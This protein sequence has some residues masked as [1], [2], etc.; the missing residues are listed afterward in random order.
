MERT[1]SGIFRAMRR[2]RWALSLAFGYALLLNALLAG[3]LDTQAVAAAL[4]PLSAAA[5]PLCG[6][7]DG[8]FSRDPANRG[9]Q[10]H[11]E[12]PLCGPA[13]PMGGWTSTAN[14]AGPVTFSAPALAFAIE[15]PRLVTAN[16]LRSRSLYRSDLDSQA[17]P[18]V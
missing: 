6:G 7:E 15:A 12:C 9:N 13:C 10:H 14:G 11:Q 17:P 1:A 18:E 4:D 3:V 8:G 16:P 5:S 2:R